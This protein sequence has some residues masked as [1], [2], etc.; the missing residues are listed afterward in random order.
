MI[1]KE[2]AGIIRLVVGAM[3]AT[4]V[5]F[6]GCSGS[7]GSGGNAG[8]NSTLPAAVARARQ[9]NAPVD[10]AIVKADNAFGL[11]LLQTVQ[12]EIFAAQGPT[13]IVVSPLSA[14]IALQVLFNGAAGTTRQA[15]AQTLQL[16][17]L[18]AQQVNDANAAL[19]ASLS[20]ADPKVQVT[21]ANSLWLRPSENQVL[22]SFTQTDES[23][24]GATVGDL[25][26]A[27]GAVNAWVSGQTSGLIPTI[28]PSGDYSNLY[29]IIANAIYFK[30]QWT[31]GFDP[32]A[33]TMNGFSE[34]DGSAQLVPMMHQSGSYS[35]LQGPNFQ[36]I[37]LPYGQGRFSMLVLLPDS[38]VT[39]A[40]FVASIPS[41]GLDTWIGQMQNSTVTVV[42]PR[43]KASFSASLKPALSTLGMGIAFEFP[44]ADLSG[45]A[46]GASVS[47]VIHAAVVDVDETGTTAASATVITV[48]TTDVGPEMTM[49]HPF[50]YAIRDDDTG[51]LMFVGMLEEP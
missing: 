50:L 10:P 35:Y 16:G 31:T 11:S 27:P 46:P 5:A 9:S 14:S 48:T 24:Y 25:A 44:G 26:G 8:S 1:L 51:E 28:L 42:L 3:L 6:G 32:N 21:I 20:A 39:L 47:D 36:M 4:T 22:P 19:Q 41:D 34:G 33:T 17:P 49:D 30:G 29:A 38:T 43:F 18:T 40:D 23:Y 15:M 12:K 45:L 13:N 7:P 2:R 37:R